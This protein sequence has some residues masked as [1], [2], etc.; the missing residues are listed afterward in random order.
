MDARIV[1]TAKKPTSK[2]ELRENRLVDVC[3]RTGYS[4]NQLSFTEVDDWVDMFSSMIMAGLFKSVRVK[5]QRGSLCDLM[6]DTTEEI[7][8]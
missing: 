6:K 1:R 2:T 8:A 4:E 5:W 7:L 3:T